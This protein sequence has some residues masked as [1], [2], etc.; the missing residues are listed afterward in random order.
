MPSRHTCSDGETLA[1]ICQGREP[2]VGIQKE[3]CWNYVVLKA[4]VI[5]FYCYLSLLCVCVS[6]YVYLETKFKLIF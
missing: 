4:F 5:Y 1:N 2:S 6:V 3:I